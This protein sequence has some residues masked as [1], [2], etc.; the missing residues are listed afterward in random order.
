VIKKKSGIEQKI[1][2]KNSKK[3][4]TDRVWLCWSDCASLTDVNFF[5]LLKKRCI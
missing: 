4:D 5:V 2:K 3:C 1:N